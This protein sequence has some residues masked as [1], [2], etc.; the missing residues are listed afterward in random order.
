MVDSPFHE[1]SKN[2]F[3]QGGPN[4]GGVRLENLGKWAITG[5]SIIMGIGGGQFRKRILVPTPG[6]KILVMPQLSYMPDQILGEKNGKTQSSGKNLTFLWRPRLPK[7]KEVSKK[8][9]Y[10]QTS[11]VIG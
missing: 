1:D 3:F 11:Y 8:F 5:T 10:D 9:L 4:F 2:I 7:Y 6:T